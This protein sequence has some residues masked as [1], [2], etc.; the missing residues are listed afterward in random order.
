MKATN[1]TLNVHHVYGTFEADGFRLL[2]CKG[3]SGREI[4]LDRS[5]TENAPVLGV[6]L[7]GTSTLHDR[8]G[9]VRLTSEHAV[10]INDPARLQWCATGGHRL[11]LLEIHK[12][13]IQS[14]GDG[15]TLRPGVQ[16]ILESADGAKHPQPFALRSNVLSVAQSLTRP[17]THI[18]CLPVWY[19]AKVMELASLSFFSPETTRTPNSKAANDER[20][21][22]VID[23]V[24]FLLERDLENPPTLEMLA[25]DVHCGPF[26]LSRLFV[27][28]TGHTMPEFLRQKRMELAASLLHSSRQGIS[29]IALSVGYTSFSAFTRGFV[30]EYGMTPSAFRTHQSQISSN[31]GLSS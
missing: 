6:S 11:L 17:P 26:Q 25:Q 19:R 30:R 3:R 1:A 21:R 2:F 29:E 15:V 13:T 28:Q 27:S 22:Q 24:M 14:M 18:A 12:D 20:I 5:L 16:Q 7:A 8:E 9:H 4:R 23:R 31:E 10:I